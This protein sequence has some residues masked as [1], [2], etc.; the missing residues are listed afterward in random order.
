[1]IGIDVDLEK[2][3]GAIPNKT[4]LA[5]H[6][7]VARYSLYRKLRGQQQL[8]FNEFNRICAYLDRNARDF[9]V[10]VDLDQY[11]DSTGKQA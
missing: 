11:K 10:D 4:R 5:N 9:L 2:L 1:M 3:R 7:G 8:N 6:L